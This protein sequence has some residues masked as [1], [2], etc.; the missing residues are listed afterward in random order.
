MCVSEHRFS[1]SILYVV[2]V[3]LFCHHRQLKGSRVGCE[4]A[5]GM[6]YHS[7][8]LTHWQGCTISHWATGSQQQMQ[9][10]SC[11]GSMHLLILGEQ[12]TPLFWENRC[13]IPRPGVTDDR[14]RE[15]E[16]V[17][18]AVF[19][20]CSDWCCPVVLPSP[21]SANP[22]S[23]RVYCSLY[24][25]SETNFL[26][27]PLFLLYENNNGLFLFLFPCC[28]FYWLMCYFWKYVTN[29]VILWYYLKW[30]HVDKQKVYYRQ[31][32]S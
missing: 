1:S 8:K 24:R 11:D 27:N 31:G 15:G 9:P 26:L 17:I 6:C 21:V 2:F 7:N 20:I 16:R 10:L 25:L 28:L 29:T 22:C 13:S 5:G 3:A 32:I 14:E 4:Q 12:E 30:V 19:D 18:M 23:W